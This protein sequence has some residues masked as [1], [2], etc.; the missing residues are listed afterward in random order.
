MT[1]LLALLWPYALE[2][3]VAGFC[4]AGVGTVLS[5]LV[6]LFFGRKP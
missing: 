1:A 2:A 5:L 3:V 6:D 4:L